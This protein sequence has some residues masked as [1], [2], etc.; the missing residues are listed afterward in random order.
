MIILG[1]DLGDRR[2]GFAVSD[3][4]GRL[5]VVAGFSPVRNRAEALSAVL[6]KADAERADYIVLGLPLN[7]NGRPGRKAGEAREFRDLL[8]QAGRKAVLW[9]ERLTTLEATRLLKD[10]GLKRRQRKNRVD[11][12]SAQRLLESYLERLKKG[13]L[14]L[15][16]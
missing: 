13:D 8:L 5:A 14:G 10:A 16:K 15:A 1:V 3:E 9:D 7:M 4:E 2:V 11:A 12:A 6:A